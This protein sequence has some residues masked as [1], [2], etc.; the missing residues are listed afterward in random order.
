MKILI[1][2]PQV[3]CKLQLQRHPSFMIKLSFATTKFVN[4]RY[5]PCT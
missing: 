3:V 4:S 1:S 5:L 2:N